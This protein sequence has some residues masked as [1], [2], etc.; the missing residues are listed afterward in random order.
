L[1]YAGVTTDASGNLYGTTTSG[2]PYG[3]GTAFKLDT[4]GNLSV[5]HSFCSQANCADGYDPEAGLTVDASGNLYGT[6][7]IGGTGGAGTAYKI[8]SSGNFTVLY[9]FCSAT[10]CADGGYPLT[11]P[12]KDASGNLYGTTSSGGSG[13]SDGTVFKLDSGG[14]YSVL[15]SFCTQ[16]NCKDGG[17]PRSLIEDAAGNFYGTTSGGGALP[18]AGTVF[19]LNS[20]GNYANI[21][22]FCSQ[23]NCTDGYIPIIAPPIPAG[24]LIEDTS[25]NLYGTTSSGGAGIGNNDVGVI[26]KLTA[27]IPT[28]DFTVSASATTLT[29][30]SPGYSGQIEITITPTGGFDQT[31]TFSSASCS[32]LPAGASCTFSPW[33]VTPGGNAATTILTIGTTA[34][35]SATARPPFIPKQR[36]LLALLLPGLFVL[37]PVGLKKRQS[38]RTARGLLMLVFVFASIGL[39]GCGGASAGGWSSTGGRG[40]GTPVGTYTV[41]VAATATNITQTTTFSLVVN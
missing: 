2:G 12:I 23:T 5:L 30:A 11:S 38:L 33:S 36:V 21:Y 6:T 28:P 24:N 19:W 13:Y 7:F 18:G 22:Y 17:S 3:G 40:G 1:P 15:H 29:I 16:G 10:L 8:D 25:G 37:L 9:T 39:S 26:F 41:T 27:V 31:V 32:G 35:S 20:A 14:N 4:G 34:A